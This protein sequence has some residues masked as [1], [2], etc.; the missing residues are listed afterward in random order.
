MNAKTA[1]AALYRAAISPHQLPYGNAY[2]MHGIVA[3]ELE[4]PTVDSSQ[5]EALKAERTDL[6][7]RVAE[8][9]EELA[10]ATKLKRRTTRK[11]NDDD[12]SGT[13]S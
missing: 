3:K 9:E 2:L 11:K 1:L 13:T 5:L 10:E 7:M 8:L 6:V 12:D 4:A